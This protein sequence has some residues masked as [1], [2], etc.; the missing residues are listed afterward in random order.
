MGV[1]PLESMKDTVRAL[2]G[3]YND[4]EFRGFQGRCGIVV[5]MLRV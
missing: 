5:A 1:F 4:I 3:V 2:G